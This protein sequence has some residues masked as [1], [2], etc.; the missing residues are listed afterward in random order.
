MI[1]YMDTS[2]LAVLAAAIFIYRSELLLQTEDVNDAMN[3]LS[4]NTRI[5][6]MPL[7]QMF[8]FSEEPKSL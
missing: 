5:K 4:E 3:I 7:L 1:G 6:V 8:L 2:L